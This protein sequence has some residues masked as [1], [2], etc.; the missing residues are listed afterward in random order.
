MG[1][2]RKKKSAIVLV[3][4]FFNVDDVGTLSGR[5]NV[6]DIEMFSALWRLSLAVLIIASPISN[7]TM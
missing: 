2:V 1:V 7:Y 5:N 4:Y 3:K 6:L